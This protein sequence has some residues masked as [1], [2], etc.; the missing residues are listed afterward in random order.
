MTTLHLSPKTFKLLFL[1]KSHLFIVT[2]IYR[3]I[4]L[5]NMHLYQVH[6]KHNPKLIQCLYQCLCGILLFILDIWFYFKYINA[7][8][9]L[10]VYFLYFDSSASS[11]GM[12]TYTNIL[13]ASLWKVLNIFY[14]FNTLFKQNN[15]Y[16]LLAKNTLYSCQFIMVKNYFLLQW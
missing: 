1:K 7:F 16:F 11:F 15:I 2:K 14:V 13:L 10:I 4:K 12:N 6:L 5:N 3:E 9:R 8:W